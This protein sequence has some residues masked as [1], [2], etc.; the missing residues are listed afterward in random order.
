MIK[1]NEISTKK[2]LIILITVLSFL[3]VCIILFLFT[4][5]PI[6]YDDMY[7]PPEIIDNNG[8]ISFYFSLTTATKR[9]NEKIIYMF[10][11]Y[12]TGIRYY[13][14]YISIEV[15]RWNLWFNKG[16]TI[17]PYFKIYSDGRETRLGQLD[18]ARK[19]L[20][21]NQYEQEPYLLEP[22]YLCVYYIDSDGSLTLLWEH[23]DIYEIMNNHYQFLQEK[24]IID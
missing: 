7:V 8:I 19:I 18:P 5:R 9:Y 17:N 2:K 1:S 10:D 21:R 23:P 13:S 14:Y 16:K 24:S 22:C 11:D 3:L 12:E 4:P 6:D 15:S 20:P